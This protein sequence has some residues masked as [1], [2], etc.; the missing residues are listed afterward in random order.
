MKGL[1]NTLAA[2]V[3]TVIGSAAMGCNTGGGGGSRP[4]AST[5]AAV[6]STVLSGNLVEA[7]WQHQATAIDSGTKVLIT[8]GTNL[9]GVPTNTAELWEAG[10][11][12]PLA[13][14]MTTARAGHR[15]V[16]LPTGEVWILGGHDATGRALQTTE[17]W[18]P[19]ART[20]RAG[21]ELLRPRDGAAIFVAEDAIVIA[22]GKGAGSVEAWSP[23]L[24]DSTLVAE[25]PGLAGQGGALGFDPAAQGFLVGGTTDQGS[26]RR[27]VAI[28][29]T[30]GS[31]HEVSGEK[32]VEGG[33]LV[34]ATL[35]GS[36]VEGYVVGGRFDGKPFTALQR[37]RTGE[38]EVVQVLPRVLQS[39]ERAVVVALRR[40]ILIAGGQFRGLPTASVE[41]VQAEGSSE[42][43]SLKEP[44]T[45]LEATILA[46]GAVLFT[47]GL[48]GDGRPVGLTELLVPPG[49]SAPDASAAF[50]RARGERAD[51]ERLVAER[52]AAV[53][54]AEGLTRTLEATTAR[55]EAE[56]ARRAEVE[57]QLA[58][59]KARIVELEAEAA[60]L[61]NQIAQLN[62]QI[63][64]L[65]GQ[66][67]QLQAQV[68][69]LQAEKAGV[70]AALATEKANVIGAREQ[71]EISDAQLAQVKREREA[72]AAQLQAEKARAEQLQ[73][74]LTAALTPPPPPPAPTPTFRVGGVSF[75]TTMGLRFR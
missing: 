59:A 33:A 34:T 35:D 39:R 70:E 52:D 61:K 58:A 73:K 41:V 21:P 22:G 15:A 19:T 67:S 8:G 40:G 23:D 69:Q 7:R 4:T 44:R 6:G 28:D 18:S 38:E 36:T 29:L 30:T 60:D 64:Q 27:P 46:D 55:L 68:A 66:V 65:N 1:T 42:A 32:F 31:A 20:F 56:T 13:E 71:T 72:L 62:G 75:G 16:V 14:S 10:R 26:P 48:A 3:V 25:A 24:S 17:L 9:R 37:I 57:G 43:P 54:K 11:S 49:V 63:A 12:S 45:D 50:A 2:V 51:A 47:G 5:G 74:D 53:A